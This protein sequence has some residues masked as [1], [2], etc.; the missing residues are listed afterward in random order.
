[1]KRLSQAESPIFRDFV[2]SL[3]PKA[4]LSDFCL[5]LFIS[6]AVNKTAPLKDVDKYTLNV[7]IGQEKTELSQLS[8]DVS[9]GEAVCQKCGKRWCQEWAKKF[10]SRSWILMWFDIWRCWMWGDTYLKKGLCQ[11]KI[12]NAVTQWN[13]R[14]IPEVLKVSVSIWVENCN[15][16]GVYPLYTVCEDDGKQYFPRQKHILA[17]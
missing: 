13:L 3:F 16:A 11:E 12:W 4:I 9:V 5:T 6:G 15:V 7:K 8:P 10:F 17:K 14:I 2:C 1:M